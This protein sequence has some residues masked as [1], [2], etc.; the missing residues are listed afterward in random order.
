MKLNC[1][2]SGSNANCYFLTNSKGEILILDCGVPLHTLVRNKGFTRFKYVVG[3]LITHVH[4]DHSL[5]VDDLLRSGVDVYGYMNLQPKKRYK[6]GNYEVI[7]FYV[8]HDVLNYGFI[9]SEKGQHGRFVY[10]TDCAN[11]P[12][13]ADVDN[14]LIECNYCNEKWDENLMSDHANLRY[15]GR[16]LE[17]HMGL[18]NLVAYFDKATK[19]ANKIILCHLSEN[20]NADKQIMLDRLRPYAETVDIATKNKEWSIE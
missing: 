20:G 16:V 13:I 19:K 10:A 2:S 3:A 11:L 4:K 1:V 8:E 5:S 9:I 7:P 12:V 17:S 14:W 6:I 18:D 15:L